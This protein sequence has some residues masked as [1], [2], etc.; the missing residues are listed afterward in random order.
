MVLKHHWTTWYIS[1]C[2][3]HLIQKIGVPLARSFMGIGPVLWIYK[4][5]SGFLFICP[6]ITS[7]ILHQGS[8]LYSAW[9]YL[10]PHLLSPSFYKIS[11]YSLELGL[12]GRPKPSLFVQVNPQ[13]V[14]LWSHF[15]FI[16]LNEYLMNYKDQWILNYSLQGYRKALPQIFWKKRLKKRA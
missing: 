2:A 3:V 11:K 16:I 10:K 15:H 8:R 6:T 12:V 7:L 14:G 9:G 4:S 5:G 13:N 1:Q